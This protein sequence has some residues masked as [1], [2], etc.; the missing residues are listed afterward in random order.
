MRERLLLIVALAVLGT[1]VLHAEVTTLAVLDFD[2]NCIFHAETYEPLSRGLSQMMTSALSPIESLRLVERQKLRDLVD[3][4]RMA[5]SGLGSD[6]ALLKIGKMSGARH[7]VFGSFMIT[8]DEKIRIDVRLIEVETGRTVKAESVTGK[9]R[10]ILE[11]IDTL[12]KKLADG[13]D[14]RLSAS[15]KAL[16]D[17]S[18][19]VPMQAVVAYSQA[20]VFEENHRD[21]D[22]YLAYRNALKIAPGFE[23][24]DR[25][26]KALIDRVKD[27]SDSQ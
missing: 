17:A 1:R 23:E 11:L 2:N 26:L 10:K 3:E 25:R 13:L 27:Q 9:T 5:Q 21:K 4:M 14:V 8:P 19:D 22:A 16:L 7:L 24:A 18:R 20:L 15:A 12:G 6:A